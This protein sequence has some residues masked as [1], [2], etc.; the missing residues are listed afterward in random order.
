MTD[1]DHDIWLRHHSGSDS[2]VSPSC[3]VN[4]NNMS[5]AYHEENVDWKAE[6]IQ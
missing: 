1:S 6:F 4:R 3:F 2:I 5:D